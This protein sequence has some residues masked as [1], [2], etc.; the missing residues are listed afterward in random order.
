MAVGFKPDIKFDYF[1]DR[2]KVINQ[3]EAG[4][5]KFLN[6]VGA[7]YRKVVKRS[8][9]SGKPTKKNPHGVSS[10]PGRPPRYH[11]KLLRDHILYQ[12]EPKN[13]AVVV[14]AM[15][16]NGKGY[17]GQIPRTLEFGG[18]AEGRKLQ[19]ITKR[20]ESGARHTRAVVTKRV[21]YTMKP[22]PFVGDRSVNWPLAIQFMNKFRKDLF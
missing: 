17:K 16:L 4:E 19:V 7:N 18:P 3:L 22:R 20:D 14:G 1:F 2:D 15:P 10:E 6:R 8:M 12:Y 11:T 21:R 5:R 9:R 13:R